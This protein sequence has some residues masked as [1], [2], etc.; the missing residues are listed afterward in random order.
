MPG[1]TRRLALVTTVVVGIAIVA[2]LPTACG[3]DNQASSGEVQVVT[4]NGEIG[5]RDVLGAFSREEAVD[6]ATEL[7]G[8]TVV[9]PTDV[10]ADG[11]ALAWIGVWQFPPR[12]EVSY[13]TGGSFTASEPGLKLTLAPPGKPIGLATEPDQTIELDGQTTVRVTHAHAE[14]PVDAV[15]YHVKS[16]D[17]TLV[18]EV[19]GIEESDV[20]AFIERVLAEQR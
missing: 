15:H 10:P 2:T 3:G 6:K 20:L 7:A 19:A 11:L 4:D 13:V 5:A 12:V 17:R 18:V 8:F 9:A 1:R 16:G 14:A